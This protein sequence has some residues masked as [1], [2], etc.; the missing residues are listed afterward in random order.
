MSDNDDIGEL[1][2]DALDRYEKM[3]PERSRRDKNLFITLKTPEDLGAHLDKSE[4]S[5]KLFRSKHGKLTSRLKTCMQPFMTLSDM[6]TAAVSASPFAP[7]ATV[8]GAVCFVLKA[9]DGVSEV[10]AWIEELFDK[11]R[12]FTARLDEYVNEVFQ[13]GFATKLLI[14][15]DASWRY[16]RVL[17]WL[18]KMG[19]GGSSPRYSFSEVTSASRPLS[20]SSPGFSTAKIRSS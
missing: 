12:D 1:W 3:V 19:D 16:S 4:R 13:R 8:L 7:A 2:E 6:I 9:A 15:L 11:L 18:S 14:S 17:S 5:F 10:Y 20:T